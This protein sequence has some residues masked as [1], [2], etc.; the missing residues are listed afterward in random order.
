MSA[1]VRWLHEGAPEPGAEAQVGPKAY[2]LMR[3]A[4]LG[5]EVPRGFVVTGAAFRDHLRQA[6][7]DPEGAP[8]D[9]RATR[10]RV[11]ESPLP[12]GVEEAVGAAYRTLGGRVAVRSSAAE[13]DRPDRSFAGRFQTFLDVLGAAEVSSR[14]RACHASLWGEDGPPGSAAAGSPPRAP[15]C[16]GQALW[17]VRGSMAVIVQA[18]VPARLS[19]VAFTEDP[20]GRHP[21][22]LVIEAAPGLGAALTAGTVSP[23]R[24]YLRREGL[25]LDRSENPLAP[26]IEP[27]VLQTIGELGVAV[28]E[29][30][31]GPQDIE[32]ALADR[33]YLLQARPVTTLPPAG[34]GD[35]WVAAN[36]QEALSDPVS[37]LTWSF[38]T[39]LIEQGRKRLVGS[40]GLPDPGSGYLKLV[41]GRP[42]FNVDYFRRFLRTVPAAP[43]EAFDTLLFG[44][45][46]PVA[47]SFPLPRPG[48]A[49]VR[50]LLTVLRHRLAAKRRMDRFLR[51]AP[52]RVATLRAA[53]LDQLA[54]AALLDA[55]DERAEFMDEAFNLH[56]LGT[57]VAGAHY[58]LL[59]RFLA[60]ALPDLV[61]RN[62]AAILI[63]RQG[64]IPTA[65]AARRVW[66]LAALAARTPPVRAWLAGGS[67]GAAVQGGLEAVPEA[68]PFREA[69]D[70]FL[71]DFGH[72]AGGEA[73]LAEPRWREDPTFVVDA[74]RAH[75]DAGLAGD[76]LRTEEAQRREK[77]AT[78]EEIERRLPWWK[79]PI[80]RQHVRWAETYAPYRELLRFEG[81]KGLAAVRDVYREMGRRFAL[82][83]AIAHPDDVFFLEEQ[84]AARLARGAEAPPG[85][86][87][88]IGGRRLKRERDAALEPPDALDAAGRA[89]HL[90][91]ASAGRLGGVGVSTGVATGKARRV[92]TPEEALDLEAGEI[93]V[94]RA[95][96]PAFTPLF[97]LAG[98]IVLEIGGLLS[99]AAVV[100]RE[101]GIPCVVN[102]RGAMER[103]PDGA[104]VRVDGGS[105]EV[106]L[107]DA[108][109]A[110][111]GPTAVAEAPRGDPAAAERS[112]A[113]R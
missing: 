83:G 5:F 12:A 72:R 54:D 35:R 16:E 25:M 11:L 28:E 60:S 19:G 62:P 10:R 100:A 59:A 9:A 27:A 101:C 56:V 106:S 3:A 48:L 63:A 2:H 103:I 76:P 78:T 31:G 44:E 51:D 96:N 6:G 37:P 42:Y 38:F 46:D 74:I 97:P 15:L 84:E 41:H 99:H 55:L 45:G 34:D 73:E 104:R 110:A 33:L 43:Q 87:Q 69:L 70:R 66:E 1:Y 75:L 36:A 85:L 107:L 26:E 112:N 21:G 39:R 77:A 32:W 105:G 113:P 81:V 52:H 49:P 13:E 65:D 64:G 61:P 24:Y 109:E 58:A 95:A 102:V 22:H 111:P 89:S 92:S 57:A 88:A 18:M 68:A 23:A 86:M 17:A 79:R 8:Q 93:L 29:A 94:A 67:G 30:L 50:L 47:L 82:R 40:L 91:A 98:G 4:A 53:A 71:S 14:I 20:T 7:V 80:F 108:K 90:P